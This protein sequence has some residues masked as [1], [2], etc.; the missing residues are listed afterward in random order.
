MAD[1]HHGVDVA[2]RVEIGFQLH[3]DRIGGG[4]QVIEDAVG[5]LLM[6]D[7][8]V[9]VAVHVKLDRLQLHHP[10]PGLVEQAQHREIGVTGEGALA[11]EFRQLDRHLIGA[12]GPGV[13][14]TDQLG[15]GDG[16]LAVEG[17]LGQRSLGACSDQRP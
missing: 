9:A 10:R 13:V 3:P 6:G 14:E 11:G 17:G 8:L 7:R 4:H 15:F 5:H 2:A 12:A 16:A 1:P